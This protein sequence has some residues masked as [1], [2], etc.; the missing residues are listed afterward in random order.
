MLRQGGCGQWGS[1]R[2]TQCTE[3]P[4]GC[5]RTRLRGA[6]T[7]LIPH[8]SAPGWGE[9]QRAFKYTHTHTH[10]HTEMKASGLPVKADIFRGKEPACQCRRRR[11]DPWVGKTPWRRKWQPT[12]VFLPG[13]FHGQSSLA[14]YSPR[15]H[16]ELDMTERTIF[17]MKEEKSGGRAAEV[18]GGESSQQAALSVQVRPP[19]RCN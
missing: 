2:K 8:P 5:L 19:E 17:R 18:G 10:T 11:F 6:R 12:P 15:G 16:K 1:I 3:Q 7:L 4:Y 9:A 14:G 13:E